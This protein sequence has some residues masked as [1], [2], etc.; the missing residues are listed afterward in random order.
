MFFIIVYFLVQQSP[1]DNPSEAGTSKEQ[2]DAKNAEEQKKQNPLMPKSAVLRLLS[3]MIKSYSSC[4]RLI[5]NYSYHGG[6]SD[7]V[8]E[9][10]RV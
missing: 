4:T 2:K 10:C 5:T 3:E 6:Q 1:N 9:V 8:V 7:L